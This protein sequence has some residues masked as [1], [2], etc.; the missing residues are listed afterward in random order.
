MKITNNLKTVLCAVNSKYVHTNLAVRSIKA[1]CTAQNPDLNI[2]IF[3]TTIN[4]SPF[5]ALSKLYEL[6]ADL[7]G[8]SCYLWNID[9]ILE[10]ADGLKKAFSGKK[11]IKVFLGGP[12][13][14]FDSVD[15][16]K[17]YPFIDFIVSGEG[18]YTVYKI[19][20]GESIENIP[21]VTYK[22][23]KDIIKK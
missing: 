23:Q 10:L 21:S 9:Y 15:V 8:F 18:E 13:V 7:Y 6:D 5:S 11:E 12:E 17:K 22:Y 20:N 16:L 19:L 3:E 4:D 2:N 14:I 1:Y